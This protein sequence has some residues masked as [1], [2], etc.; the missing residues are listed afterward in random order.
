M[1]VQGVVEKWGNSQRIRLPLA[2]LHQANL[3]CN[4]CVDIRVTEDGICIS[5]PKRKTIQELFLY[6][7]DKDLTEELDWGKPVGDEAW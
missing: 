2:L 4:D 7:E 3:S 6:C 5:K 1:N